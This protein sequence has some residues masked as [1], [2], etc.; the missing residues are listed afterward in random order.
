[1]VVVVGVKVEAVHVE[2]VVVVEAIDV[3]KVVVL[4]DIELAGGFRIDTDVGFIF[5]LIGLSKSGISSSSSFGA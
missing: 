1:M 5:L 3:V 2:A 4:L